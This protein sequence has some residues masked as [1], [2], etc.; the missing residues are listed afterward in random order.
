MEAEL[1]PLISHYYIL[2]FQGLNIAGNRKEAFRK[3]IRQSHSSQLLLCFRHTYLYK[4][5]QL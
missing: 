1:L 4:Y 2:L 5:G 3:A